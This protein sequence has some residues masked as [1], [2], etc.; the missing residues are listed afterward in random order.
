[1]SKKECFVISPIGESGSE[2]RRRADQ[3]L[4]HVIL[5]SV[6]E[7]GFDESEVVRADTISNPG[8]ITHQ[9]ISSII[10]SDL[11]IAD[12]TGN[13][14]NVYYELAIRHVLRK[15]YVQICDINTP[16]P[17]DV[18]NQ[19]TIMFDYKDLDSVE[20]AKNNLVE[21]A[22]NALSHPEKLM[23]PVHEG[24]VIE[25]LLSSTSSS[26]QVLAQLLLTVAELSSNI[27]DLKEQKKYPDI[28]VPS[29]ETDKTM[30]MISE[31]IINSKIRLERLLPIEI[32][33][34]LRHPEFG[35]GT[36]I[37]IIGD[38]SV[39]AKLNIEF[40]HGVETVVIGSSNLER[41]ELDDN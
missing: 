28:K 9:I 19:R 34:K 14:P 33:M 12:L 36:V 8:A 27:R 15:P 21:Y 35:I 5:P 11:V 20:A 39:T 23:T 32:G 2:I 4:R 30:R 3:V 25:N 40:K 6:K 24:L 29:K 18:K 1:M 41:L 26:D 10:N 13:N 37:E 38:I 22:R 17:F 16:L 31:A 7:C